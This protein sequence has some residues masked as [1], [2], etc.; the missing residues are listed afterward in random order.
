MCVVVRTVDYYYYSTVYYR[1]YE[2]EQVDSSKTPLQAA[3]S[4]SPLHG[5][6]VYIIVLLH[7]ERFPHVSI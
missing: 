6:I 5:F 1:E 2:V 4:V 3:T 7:A